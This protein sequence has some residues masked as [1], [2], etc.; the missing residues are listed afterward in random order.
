ML[1]Q[2]KTLVVFQRE[3][4]VWTVGQINVWL[5]YTNN[6]LTGDMTDTVK[7]ADGTETSVV[8]DVG[9][10]GIPTAMVLSQGGPEEIDLLT[11]GWL[12][13]RWC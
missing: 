2:S 3:L 12:Q 9:A 10:K 11:W 7:L 6:E 13:E 4:Q 8:L 5:C 1:Q